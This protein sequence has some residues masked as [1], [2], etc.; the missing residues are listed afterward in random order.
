MN[1]KSLLSTC[2]L[3][4]LSGCAAPTLKLVNHVGPVTY[5]ATS[6]YSSK[7]TE[8]G[9]IVVAFRSVHRFLPDT[10]ADYQEC[11]DVLNSVAKEYTPVSRSTVNITAHEYNGVTGIANTTCTYTYKT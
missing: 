2:L 8:Q 3:V 5:D 6:E 1:L 11:S 9:F 10:Q 7:H 4:F